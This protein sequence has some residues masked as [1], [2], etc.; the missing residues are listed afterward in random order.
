MG[1]YCQQH[2]TRVARRNATR[3]SA[4]RSGGPESG[5]AFPFI[6]PA[7]ERLPHGALEDAGQR[8]RTSLPESALGNVGSPSF[9][10]TSSPSMFQAID[11]QGEEAQPIPHWDGISQVTRMTQTAQERAEVARDNR[12]RAATRLLIGSSDRPGPGLSPPRRPA[13]SVQ[14]MP[15]PTVPQC[16]I[17]MEP[18]AG[19]EGGDLYTLECQHLFHQVCIDEWV[20]QSQEPTRS[21]PSCRSPIT[22]SQRHSSTNVGALG[23]ALLQESLASA[24]QHHI[25]TP[26]RERSQDSF[27]SIGQGDV[28]AESMFP[29]WLSEG[30]PLHYC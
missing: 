23:T 3:P 19:G 30:M 12:R 27:M 6:L 9:S 17:C 8:P 18:L 15:D 7:F 20:G 1:T 5:C 11:T 28:I 13:G 21:C 24:T 25:G 29:A 14:G 22:I 2:S 4:E 26:T 16:V 10:N